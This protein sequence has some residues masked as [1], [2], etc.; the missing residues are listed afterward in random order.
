MVDANSVSNYKMSFTQCW[1]KAVPPSATMAQH[2]SSIGLMPNVCCR[3]SYTILSLI[4]WDLP[5][6]TDRMVWSV[7]VPLGKKPSIKIQNVCCDNNSITNHSPWQIISLPKGEVVEPIL[8]YYWAVVHINPTLS[9]WVE[10]HQEM[11]VDECSW[12]FMNIHQ[13]F[14]KPVHELC[15]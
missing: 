10:F 11:N 13:W 6:I 15:S 14:I 8:A 2:W 12:T 1:I 9:R 3:W 4:I 7:T 5:S